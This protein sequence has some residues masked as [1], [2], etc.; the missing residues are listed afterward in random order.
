MWV[1][2]IFGPSCKPAY[3]DI[4]SD[5]VDAMRLTNPQEVANIVFSNEAI[6]VRLKEKFMHSGINVLKQKTGVSPAVTKM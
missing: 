4:P 5:I 2:T 3:V 6:P 1:C